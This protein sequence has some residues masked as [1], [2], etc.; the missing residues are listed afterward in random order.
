M[1]VAKGDDAGC[2]LSLVLVHRPIAGKPEGVCVGF[3]QMVM[4]P[5]DLLWSRFWVVFREVGSSGV[6]KEHREIVEGNSQG[7]KVLAGRNPK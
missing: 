1:S 3:A 4:F 5:L 7:E 6:E 2:R